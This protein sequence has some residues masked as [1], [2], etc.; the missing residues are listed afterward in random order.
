VRAAVVTEVGG[1]FAPEDVDVDEPIGREVLVD[2]R[3]SGL[4]HS[5]LHVVEM[6]HSVTFPSVRGHEIAGV[7]VAVGPDVRNLAEG[8]HVVGCLVQWCGECEPCLVGRKTRCRRPAA[9]LRGAGERPRLSRQGAEV[10]QGNGMAGF[11][12]QVLTHENQLTVI[13]PTMPFAQAAVI[14]CSVVTGIGA[15]EHVANV[16]AGE[17]IVVF[18]C[19]GVGLNII[20]GAAIAGA[21]EI[22]AVDVVD[23]KLEWASRFGATHVVNSGRDDP[24]A[25]IREIARSGADH[26]F[27]VVGI[28]VTQQQAWSCLGVGGRAYLMGMSAPGTELVIDTSESHRMQKTVEQVYLGATDPR[29]DIP[30][31]VELYQTGALLLDELV[32][33]TISIDEMNEAYA[34]LVRGE[35]LRSVITEF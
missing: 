3:A 7:V 19:G 31:Y 30:R 11:A 13:D 28:S 4:C 15:V 10:T 22:I 20:N 25:A 9:T 1:R 12:S 23:A 32:T 33:D 24:V 8:D 35:T 21:G 5:D 14:G 27:E 18:G 2:V 6:G 34:A 17:T 26:A 29:R 16:G